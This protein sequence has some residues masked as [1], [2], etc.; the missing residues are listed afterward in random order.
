MPSRNNPL[1]EKERQAAKATQVAFDVGSETQTV[2]KKL[3]LDNQLTPSDQVRQILAL[4]VKSRAVRPRLTLS[5][6]EQDFID[7]AKRYGLDESDRLQIK[8]LAAQEL[9]TFA[10]A[11]QP[12]E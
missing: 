12:Q 8:E 6:S 7:L 9:I 2:I 1:W 4:P 3:A 10:A 5:L 11:S